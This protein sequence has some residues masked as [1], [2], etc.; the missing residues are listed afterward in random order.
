MRRF[1]VWTMDAKGYC[2]DHMSVPYSEYAK[3]R[4]PNGDMLCNEKIKFDVFLKYARQNL[5]VDAVATGH[6]VR[7]S[8]GDF[9]EKLDGSPVRQGASSC[10]VIGLLILSLAF[11]PVFLFGLRLS[12]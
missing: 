7:S 9:L 6:Y 11:I 3:G 8:A 2:S 4:T 1:F 12:C 5:G 10:V